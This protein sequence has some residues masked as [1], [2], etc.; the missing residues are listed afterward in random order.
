MLSAIARAIWNALP[1]FPHPLNDFD[2]PD[3]IP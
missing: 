3:Q 1:E 2:P